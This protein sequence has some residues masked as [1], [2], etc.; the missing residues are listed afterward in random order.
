MKLRSITLLAVLGL[1][2]MFEVTSAPAQL[3]NSINPPPIG[4]HCFVPGYGVF[5]VVYGPAY[6]GISCT[7]QAPTQNGPQFMNGTVVQ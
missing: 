6:I 4:Y 5:P 2:T 7:V 3:A 1:A